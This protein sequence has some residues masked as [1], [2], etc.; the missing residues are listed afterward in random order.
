MEETTGRSNR[1]ARPQATTGGVR[2]V[3]GL[4]RVGLRQ[5]G[6][7]KMGVNVGTVR[8][9]VRKGLLHYAR[10]DRRL[11]RWT[12]RTLSKW[13]AETLPKIAV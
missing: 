11:I 12:S 6:N 3:K 5:R 9:D 10:K 13:K 7:E 8:Y 1:K 2:A 4:Y